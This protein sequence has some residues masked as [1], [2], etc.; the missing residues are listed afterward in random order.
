MI[1]KYCYIIIKSDEHELNF[2]NQYHNFL[3]QNTESIF[4]NT[5][6]RHTSLCPSLDTLFV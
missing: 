4:L 5:D 3:T 2:P 6:S 1:K